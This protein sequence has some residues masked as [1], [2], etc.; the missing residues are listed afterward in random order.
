MV[1]FSPTATGGFSGTLS[2]T[3]NATNQSSP[4]NIPLSGAGGTLEPINISIT[5][6]SLNF[7]NVSIGTS[8]DQT[9]TITNPSGST[10]T[11]A[12][13][14]GV[15]SAP[16]SLVSGGGAFSLAPGQSIR[17]TVRFSPMAA[18]ASSATL[19]ITHNATNQT[20]PANVPLNG[21]GIV[22]VINLSVDPPSVDFGSVILGQLSDQKI[23]ITNQ[24]SSTGILTGNVGLLSVPFILASGWGNFSLAPGQ[25]MSVTVRYFPMTV[26]PASDNLLISHNAINVGSPLAVPLAGNG[27]SPPTV[28]DVSLN[29]SSVNFGEVTV[30]E[31]AD[32]T[33]AITNSPDSNGK[34]TGSVGTLPAPFSV[35]TGGGVFSLS[36]SQTQ[37]V[38]VRLSATEEGPVSASL[39]ITHNGTNQGNPIT[40]PLTGAGVA[41]TAI[42]IS[43]ISAPSTAKPGGRVSIQNTVTNYGTTVVNNVTVK[44]Y[45]SA[46]TRIDLADTLIGKRFITNLAPGASSGP[47]ST[48][49][50]FPRTV[51]PGTY[52]IGAIVGTNSNF[53]PKGITLCLPLSK[54][55]LLSPKNRGTNIATIPTLEWSDVDGATS[56]EVQVGTDSKFTD[57]VASMADLKNTQWTVAPALSAD[58]KYFWR[59]RAANACGLG[60]WSMTWSFK[61]L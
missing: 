29:P 21:T 43:F 41:P 25:S 44:F 37:T 10:G 17:V 38:T 4:I 45:L 32:Q 27:V 8:S 59:V 7:G 2:I 51:A 57:V 13:N 61:T 15:L 6:G 50:T 20:S 60:P 54:S 23:T 39:F 40:I 16:F 42:A 18:G 34:L 55:T 53:D 33:I 36:P 46:D 30:G 52:F 56:Y 28:I 11:L 31:S 14:V 26:G 35:V 22:G 12:G 47:V 19:V 24:P 5:P 49:V 1:R 58:T 9:V 48:Q 3:H